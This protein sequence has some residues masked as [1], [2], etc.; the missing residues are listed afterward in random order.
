M[1]KRTDDLKSLGRQ[2]SLEI[3]LGIKLTNFQQATVTGNR[4]R[5][6]HPLF[7]LLHYPKSSR[8]YSHIFDR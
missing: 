2:Q 3:S 7:H 6:K 8:A 4:E 5:L 1:L